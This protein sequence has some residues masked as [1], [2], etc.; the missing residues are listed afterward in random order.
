MQLSNADAYKARQE[1][2]VAGLSGS[3]WT[4]T[5]GLLFVIPACVLLLRALL[6][7]CTV[8]GGAASPRQWSATF[9][10]A[11]EFVVLVLPTLLNLTALAGWAVPTVAVAGAGAA[12]LHA[13]AYAARGRALLSMLDAPDSG[14]RLLASQRRKAFV[15]SFRSGMMLSTCVRLAA[16]ARSSAGGLQTCA[17]VAPP[18]RAPTPNPRSVIAILA[19]DFP[20][21]P[22]RYAKT[23][24][25]GVSIVRASGITSL[26]TTTRAARHAPACSPAPVLRRWTWA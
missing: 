4:E 9:R 1:A 3:S 23:E 16:R 19:V 13:L 11:T 21:F 8:I 14:A 15:N 6:G 5:I 26:A 12:V 22:R 17:R 25:F 7:W 10:F 24:T 18:A 2:F 20:V